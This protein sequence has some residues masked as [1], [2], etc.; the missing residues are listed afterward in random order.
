MQL[1]EMYECGT[2]ETAPQA[3]A[4]LELQRCIDINASLQLH[5][6]L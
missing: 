3:R 1:Y 2:L 5:S 6:V 4:G